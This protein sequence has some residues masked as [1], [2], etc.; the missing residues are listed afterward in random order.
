MGWASDA[1]AYLGRLFLFAFAEIRRLGQCE[2][3]DLLA[4]DGADVMVSC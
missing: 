2:E 4:G 1:F 3:N